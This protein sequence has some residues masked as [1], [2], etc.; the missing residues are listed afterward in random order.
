LTAGGTGK[1][2]CRHR[3]FEHLNLLAPGRDADLGVDAGRF[4]ECFRHGVPKRARI[5]LARSLC[6]TG[7]LHVFLEDDLEVRRP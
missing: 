5:G 1:G 3:N 4:A 7:T 6:P 2:G